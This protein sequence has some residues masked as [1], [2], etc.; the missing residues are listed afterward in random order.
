MK[1]INANNK[2]YSQMIPD[3]PYETQRAKYILLI[4]I[5]SMNGQ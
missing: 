4:T 3:K 1:I 5:I 2:I